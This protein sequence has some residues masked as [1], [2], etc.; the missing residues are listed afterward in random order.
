ML[1]TYLR[2]AVLLPPL[3]FRF[4]PGHS[5][6][7]AVLRVLSGI[8]LAVNHGDFAALVL[9]DLSAA[10]DTVGHDI[11]LRRLESGFEIADAV[12]DWFRTCL[13]G[14]RHAIGSLRRFTIVGPHRPYITY[15]VL[16]ETLNPAQSIIGRAAICG[17]PQGSVLG[18]LPILFILYVAD[19]AALI[20]DHGRS[21][22][23]SPHQYADD[24]H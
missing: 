21:V 3:Q 5:T 24:A 18:P 16:V 13:S 4:R 6:E 1:L 11:L 20:E 23:T 17:V 10:F 2:D 9:L 19:L 15:T 12:L 14:R 22:S 8:L 7:T